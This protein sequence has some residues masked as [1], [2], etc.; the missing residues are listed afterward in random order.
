ML[1]AEMGGR[2]FIMR[3]M[4]AGGAYIIMLETPE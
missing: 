2:L 4:E 3:G 1:G